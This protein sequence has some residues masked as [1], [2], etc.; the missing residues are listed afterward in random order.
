MDVVAKYGEARRQPSKLTVLN[1]IWNWAFTFALVT[2][3]AL[4]HDRAHIVVPAPYE[5]EVGV[6]GFPTNVTSTVWV[7]MLDTADGDMA[8]EPPLIVAHRGETVRI[9]LENRGVSG[10]E[11]ILGTPSELA[12]HA[13]MMR[14][15]PEM[16]HEDPNSLRLRP[17]AS[18]EIIWKFGVSDHI[19][20][21]CLVPGHYEVGMRG[22]VLVSGSASIDE[23]KTSPAVSRTAKWTKRTRWAKH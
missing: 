11:F 15:M 2:S 19:E 10:H 23:R 20:F 18:G 17:G 22:K 7:R 9:I 6:P 3:P 4:A 1:R 13:A 21:A 16:V 12:E 14:K 8:F 5:S